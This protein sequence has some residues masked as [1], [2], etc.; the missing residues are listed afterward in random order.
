MDTQNYQGHVIVLLGTGGEIVGGAYDLLNR[1]C[2]TEA[3]AALHG[4][5][6]A[7]FAPLFISE[8]HGLTHPVVSKN[9]IPLKAE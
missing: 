3:L 6:H 1:L 7:L 9:S 5:H 2:S 8:V 4:L